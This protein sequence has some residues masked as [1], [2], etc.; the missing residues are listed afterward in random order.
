MPGNFSV[1]GKGLYLAKMHV[2]KVALAAKDA[3]K[4]VTQRQERMMSRLL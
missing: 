3:D 4:A 1:L 2:E